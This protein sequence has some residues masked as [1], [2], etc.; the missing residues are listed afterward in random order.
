MCVLEEEREEV[1]DCLENSCC[2]QDERKWALGYGRNLWLRDAN[3]FSMCILEEE[4]ESFLKHRL[5]AVRERLKKEWLPTLP[6]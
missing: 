3:G 5:C 1:G 2:N 4:P 6:V